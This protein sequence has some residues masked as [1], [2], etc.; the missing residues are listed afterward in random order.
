MKLGT[1]YRCDSCNGPVKPH[2][3]FFGEDLPADFHEKSKEIA[4]CDL[5]IVIGTAL[6]VQPFN[7]L[8]GK[9]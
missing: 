5:M 1:I 7:K 6:A 2:I 8:V 4:N 3:V 9:E